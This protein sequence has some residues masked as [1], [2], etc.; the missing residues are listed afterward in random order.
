MFF[1]SIDI[2]I[3]FLKGNKVLLEEKFPVTLEKAPI[4]R[5]IETGFN[6]CHG[7]GDGNHLYA[8]N[9]IQSMVA[10]DTCREHK[11]LLILKMCVVLLNSKHKMT[12]HT[13][14]CASNAIKPRRDVPYIIY[15][16]PHLRLT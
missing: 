12:L 5:D 7:E 13:H 3:L 9:P 1:D 2:K 16:F 14:S 15:F 6:P 4:C 10:V 8:W 11:D